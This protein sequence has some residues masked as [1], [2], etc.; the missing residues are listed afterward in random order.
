MG[1]EEELLRIAR[2]LEKMVAR[3]N[4][5]R[6]QSLGHSPRPQEARRVRAWCPGGACWRRAREARAGLE[7]GAADAG[8]S[9]PWGLLG[10]P[11]WVCARPRE[12]SRILRDR[13]DEACAC[14]SGQVGFGGAG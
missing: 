1:Q 5:V 6:L 2:K 12:L 11:G 4:T 7:G 13:K 3:K 10:T 14:P 8:L 9:A